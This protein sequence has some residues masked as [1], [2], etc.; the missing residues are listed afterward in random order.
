MESIL[1]IRPAKQ[2]NIL[3]S[4]K[5]NM[6]IEKVNSQGLKINEDIGN[7]DGKVIPGVIGGNRIRWN[8][9]LRMYPIGYL[10]KPEHRE[11]FLKLVRDCKFVN[12]KAG[13][14]DKGRPIVTADPW[15]YNDPFFI[16]RKAMIKLEELSA[17]LKSSDP[18]QKIFSEYL[19]SDFRNYKVNEDGS[20]TSR[21]ARFEVV[22]TNTAIHNSQRNRIQSQKATKLLDNLNDDKKMKIAMYLGIAP[23]EDTDRQ[24][25]DDALWKICVAT[26][27]PLLAKKELFMNLAEL[28]TEKLSNRYLIS[29]ARSRGIL[30][31]TKQGFLLNGVNIGNTDYEV[32]SYFD[33]KD[34]EDVIVT[35]ENTLLTRKK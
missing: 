18:F 29:K 6:L 33:N 25:I 20:T 9:T 15:D 3:K 22:D 14:P 27:G 8:D 24:L 26:E 7:Y 23:S 19:K 1:T 13:H 5:A 32:E 31:K 16:N 17:T 11:E 28:A 34:N 12:D 2:S 10:S 21:V 35:L 30:K 4:I